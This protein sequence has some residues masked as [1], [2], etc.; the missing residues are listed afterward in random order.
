MANRLAMRIAQVAPLA[1]SVPPRLYGGTERVVSWL[2]EDLVELGHDVTLFATG[3]SV[4][5]A[6][7]VP[8]WPTALRLSRRRVDPIVAQTVSLQHV[9]ER[10]SQFDIIHF[11]TDWTHLPLL[12]TLRVP[13]LTTMH[14]RLDLP[15]LSELVRQ[16]PN[17]PFVSISENQ[18]GPLLGANWAGT[19]YHGMPPDL[20]GCGD[21]GGGYLSFLGR[22]TP[23]K[24]PEA[25]IRLAR[26]AKI[27]LRIA[28]KVPRDASRYVRESI[29]PHIDGELIRF[30]GEVRD[31]EKQAFL[32]NSS[33][34]LFPI[35]WPEPFGLVMIEAMA[36]GTP[37][38]AFRRGSVPEII[39]DGVSGFVVDNEL[40]AAAALSRIADLD[41]HVIRQAFERRFTTR[42]MT[43]DYLGIYQRLTG[44]VAT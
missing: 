14:G 9:A 31:E 32:A 10:S 36:C 11:H 15:G 21:G 34:L 29:E 1:E 18:R 38:I 42:R 33:A 35:E 19:V 41:R 43:I 12:T 13:F 28:A 6:S 23:E 4:T 26:D 40:Q 17:A 27:P 30:V 24:G 8:V 37:V 22:L 7:L 44:Q 5:R 39:Q 20:L 25:A 16:F 3:D 2:S